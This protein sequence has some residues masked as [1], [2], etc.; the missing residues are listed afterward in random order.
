MLTIASTQSSRLDLYH[1]FNVV[2][3]LRD[4]GGKVSHG[5]S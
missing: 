4:Q 3:F 2:G 1:L 5:F